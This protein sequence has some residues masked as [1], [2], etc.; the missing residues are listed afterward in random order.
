[1]DATE[2]R[3]GNPIALLPSAPVLSAPAGCLLA[4]VHRCGQ[5]EGK[6]VKEKATQEVA[7]LSVNFSSFKFDYKSKLLRIRVEIL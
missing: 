2:R 3:K 1:M 7:L 5:R 6:E 4:G